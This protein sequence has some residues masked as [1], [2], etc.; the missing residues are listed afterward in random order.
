MSDL[1]CAYCNGPITNTRIYRLK[2][3]FVS[4]VPEARDPAYLHGDLTS[5]VS[6]VDWSTCKTVYQYLYGLLDEALEE[7][8]AQ[9]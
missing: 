9:S 3:K 2:E 7:V 5:G 8:Y 4:R 6:F 1:V